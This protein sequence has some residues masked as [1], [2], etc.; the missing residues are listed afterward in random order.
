MSATFTLDIKKVAAEVR[1]N[2]RVFIPAIQVGMKQ[3]A[4]DWLGVQQKNQMTG[5][6][7]GLNRRTG[8]LARSWAVTTVG[9]GERFVVR[10]ATNTKYAKIHQTGGVIRPKNGKYL[11]FM[12]EGKFVRKTSVTIPKRLYIYEEWQ[13]SAWT[14]LRPRIFA[15]IYKDATT[16][17]KGK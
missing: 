1:N 5:G 8:T 15:N 7:P 6:H 13:K 14:Y 2:I 10:V 17:S 11:A 12:Y 9:W 4:M 16:L 3:G